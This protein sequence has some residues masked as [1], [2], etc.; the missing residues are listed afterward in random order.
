MPVKKTEKTES[1]EKGLTCK[2]KKKITKAES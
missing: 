1:K 2:K